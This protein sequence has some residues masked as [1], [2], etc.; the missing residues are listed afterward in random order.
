M[1]CGTGDEGIGVD[2]DVEHVQTKP[3]S[4][5]VVSR[6]L[7]EESSRSMVSRFGTRVMLLYSTR[8]AT[9]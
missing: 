5:V 6:R 3:V 9:L 2:K 1:G 8:Y 4:S 7:W